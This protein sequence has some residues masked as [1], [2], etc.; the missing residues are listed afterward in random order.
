MVDWGKVQFCSGEDEA[1]AEECEAAERKW[2]ASSLLRPNSRAVFP[3]DDGRLARAMAALM[4]EKCYRLG[5]DIPDI[6]SRAARAK[7][8]DI[9][10]SD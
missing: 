2:L 7:L 10:G 9:N 6:G 5:F 1:D 8:D 3:K 4:I